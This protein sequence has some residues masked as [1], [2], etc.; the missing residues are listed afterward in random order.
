MQR[1]I[2]I[3]A[4]SDGKVAVV[5]ADKFLHPL[6]LE[7]HAVGGNRDHVVVG[8]G[9]AQLECLA[10]K[11]FDRFI[12]ELNFKQWFTADKVQD[13]GWGG[14][15]HKLPLKQP[16][17]NLLGRLPAH[18]AAG[19]VALVAVGAGQVACLGDTEGH[20]LT[21][22][23]VLLVLLFGVQLAVDA[24]NL[25]VVAGEILP[26]HVELISRCRLHYSPSPSLVASY[27][28]TVPP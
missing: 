12:D 28:F 7:E 3:D 17:H 26:G 16:V 1:L 13:D 19:L 14:V 27:S 11:I 4:D 22:H 20:I 15:V 23:V 2:P 9:M 21:E 6:V 8:P 5:F 18:P 10:L 24:G 25:V